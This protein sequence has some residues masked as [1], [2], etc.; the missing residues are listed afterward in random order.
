MNHIHRVVFNRSLAVHQ[1]VPEIAG[2]RGAN[3]TCSSTSRKPRLTTLMCACLLAWCA[4]PRALGATCDADRDIELSSC[5]H[6]A[7][8]GDTVV[9]ASDI[10][11]NGAVPQSTV[12]LTLNGNGFS[13]IGSGSIVSLAGTLTLTGFASTE[14]DVAANG[15]TVSTA[16]AV[17]LGRGLFMQGGTLRTTAAFT[18]N[19]TRMSLGSGC[20]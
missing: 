4:M 13:L 5:I 7:T 20:R 14:N 16:S 1:A 19:P 17:N 8:A 10:A 11:L 18:Y 2:G 3:T 9:L 6:N 12:S 15:G